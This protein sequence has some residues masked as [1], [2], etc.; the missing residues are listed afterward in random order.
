MIWMKTLLTLAIINCD[1]KAILAVLNTNMNGTLGVTHKC[2][3]ITN[4]IG[5]WIA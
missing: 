4:V 3:I 2:S 5:G 1:L